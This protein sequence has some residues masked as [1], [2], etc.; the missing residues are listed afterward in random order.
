MPRP[1]HIV[2]DSRIVQVL[3]VVVVPTEVGRH[4]CLLQH[5]L[6]PLHQHL[7][8]TVL[9]HRPNW[10]ERGR[11][12]G[13]SKCIEAMCKCTRTMCNKRCFLCGLIDLHSIQKA[14][15]VMAC[16]NRPLVLV[17]LLRPLVQ[18]VLDELPLILCSLHRVW[19]WRWE[20]PDRGDES[21]Q[22]GEPCR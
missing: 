6:Q 1:H 16:N 11:V 20:R 12:G 5:G 14:T 7:G 3:H 10:R 9:S 19:P 17:A 4:S 15:W 21:V 8:G 13:G 22:P 18:S 2:L